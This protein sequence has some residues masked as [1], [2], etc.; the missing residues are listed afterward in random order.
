MIKETKHLTCIVCPVGCQLTVEMED[1]KVVSVSGNLCKRGEKYAQTECVNPVR[2]LTT[3][4]RVENSAPLSV[5]SQ[6]PL[7][8]NEIFN[9]MHLINQVTIKR[10]TPIKVGDVII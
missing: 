10:G 2:T 8:K 5:R 3:T 1:G 7:P 6:E 9:C 4:I